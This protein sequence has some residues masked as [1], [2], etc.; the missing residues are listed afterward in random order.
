MNWVGGSVESIEWMEGGRR[1]YAV[2]QNGVPSPV[3]RKRALMKLKLQ[4]V[5]A[6]LLH[7]FIL[8]VK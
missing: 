4:L 7:Y 2:P 3:T 8:T 5:R 6:D 1:A